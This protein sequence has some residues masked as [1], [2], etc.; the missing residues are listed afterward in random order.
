MSWLAPGGRGGHNRA[1][2]RSPPRRFAVILPYHPVGDLEPGCATWEAL[3]SPLRRSADVFALASPWGVLPE[4]RFGAWGSLMEV[5][6]DLTGR[7]AAR[8]A[9]DR[10]RAW[11]DSHG[12]RY[13]RIALVA[14][15]PM[16]APWTQGAR[17]TRAAGRVKI[18]KA[19][20]ASGARPPQRS[21]R[22]PLVG[23]LMGGDLQ[24]FPEEVAIPPLAT[25][26]LAGVRR[27]NENVVGRYRLVPDDPH[28]FRARLAAHGDL[29]ESRYEPVPGVWS[30]VSKRGE[31]FA[32]DVGVSQRYGRALAGAL[33]CHKRSCSSMIPS[34]Q[35]Q[36]LRPGLPR[37][38]RSVR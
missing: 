17:G 36:S 5:G 20:R 37:G 23:V 21:A 16:M 4:S 13:Q 30:S 28:V 6:L 2:F 24:L 14:E 9:A 29:L 18:I 34:Y 32:L 15:G 19:G 31:D 38:Q 22:P 10:I 25:A 3:A 8:D 26:V 7:Q 1:V 27:D 33:R 11:L 35:V 12:A